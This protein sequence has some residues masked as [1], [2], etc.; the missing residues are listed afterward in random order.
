[1]KRYSRYSLF[2][3]C[4]CFLFTS[5]KLKPFLRYYTVLKDG[6]YPHFNR[7]DR[8]TGSINDYRLCYDVTFYKFDIRPDIPHK[9]ISG[10]VEIT[11][12]NLS[13]YTTLL[14]DLHP[15]LNVKSISCKGPKIS[16]RRKRNA[17][18]VTFSEAQKKGSCTTIT[19]SYE[20]KP[21]NLLG[22]CAV[23]W[24]EDADKKPWVNTLCQGL[25]ASMIWPC[26]DLLYDEADSMHMRIHVPKGLTAI[27]NGRLISKTETEKEDVYD[28]TCRNTI[29][30]YNISFTIG[31]YKELV[32]PYTN[33]SGTHDLKV[34]VLPYN[35]ER[36]KKHFT[37]LVPEMAFL[38][39]MYGEYPWYNDGYKIFESPH[40]G[41][42]EHQSAIALG[43]H[44]GNNGWGFD[45]LI[46]HE[47]SHEW[48]GNS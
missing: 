8:L 11:I 47:T 23:N 44:F 26:K 24:K 12:S 3:L 14:L 15:T 25:G 5:C 13:D 17:L 16:Y 48:W 29:N 2:L 33:A 6:K 38:E 22:H 37:Q 27:S 20:G 7:F 40:S 41:A 1:M 45:D 30:V 32:F 42:M 43:N 34:F 18:F 35:E 19:I 31:N 46:V 4:L 21:V 9:R 39:R 28:W 36:A 10:D